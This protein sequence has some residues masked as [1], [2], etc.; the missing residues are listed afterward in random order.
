MSQTDAF[1]TLHKVMRRQQRIQSKLSVESSETEALGSARLN[2]MFLLSEYMSTL[3][4]QVKVLRHYSSQ[5]VDLCFA[6]LQEAR[7]LRESGLKILL[8]MS[9]YSEYCD[10]SSRLYCAL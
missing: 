10:S 6:L 5:V 4:V 9:C 1:G 3:P 8:S 7:P 2:V